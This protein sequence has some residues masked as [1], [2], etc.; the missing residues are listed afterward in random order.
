M[1]LAGFYINYLLIRAK[2]DHLALKISEPPSEESCLSQ[3]QNK[4]T[5]I[6]IN[7]NLFIIII[8]NKLIVCYIYL[9][10][11]IKVWLHIRI[12]LFHPAYSIPAIRI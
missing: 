11:I 6:N 9:N 3:L 12:W 7:R 5:H 2:I 10:I 4:A 8:A 1:R